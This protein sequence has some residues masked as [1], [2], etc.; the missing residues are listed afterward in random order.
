MSSYMPHSTQY[1]WVAHVPLQL[2][3]FIAGIGIGQIIVYSSILLIKMYSILG[4]P[5]MFMLTG[6]R[7]MISDV[8][9]Y[10]LEYQLFSGGFS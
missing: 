10:D 8:D 5:V 3:L 7:G 1:V 2:M 4:L 9:F 6:L